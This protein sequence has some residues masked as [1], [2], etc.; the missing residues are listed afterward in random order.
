M[1][2]RQL[3]HKLTVILVQVVSNFNS[4]IYCHHTP[5]DPY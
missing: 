4:V 3:N 1:C 5:D 2:L